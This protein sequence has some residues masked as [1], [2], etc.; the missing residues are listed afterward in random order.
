M[1]GASWILP[2]LHFVTL[3]FSRATLEIYQALGLAD[4]VGALSADRGNVAPITA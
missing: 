2:G 3:N 4:R 1:Y